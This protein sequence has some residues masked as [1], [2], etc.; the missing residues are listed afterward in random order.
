MEIEAA[1]GPEVIF[2]GRSPM[3]GSILSVEEINLLPLV[4]ETLPVG[5]WIIDAGGRIVHGN[6]AGL[7]IWA[8][9]RYVG[10]ERF[11]EYKG[12]WADTGKRIEAREWAGARAIEKGETSIDEVIDIECFDGTRKTMLN[13]AMPIKDAEGKVLGAIIVNQDIT[14][15]R[16]LEK[17]REDLIAKLE[18]A[19]AQVRTL[20]GLLPICASCKRIRDDKGTWNPV[21]TYIRERTDTEFS[22]GLCPECVRRLYP[23]FA[24]KLD[25]GEPPLP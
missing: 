13:S 7:R 11:G 14:E 18:K 15:K 21:E 5:V 1:R 23:D 2:M 16:R 25:A 10:V 22:H 3:E 12:W 6:P 4:L 24:D 20:S 9:A 8:G 19:L 17:E